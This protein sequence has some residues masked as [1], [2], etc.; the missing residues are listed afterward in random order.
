MTKWKEY[1][2]NLLDEYEEEPMKD[3]DSDKRNND[4]MTIMMK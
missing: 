4:P 3:K 2:E 1:F